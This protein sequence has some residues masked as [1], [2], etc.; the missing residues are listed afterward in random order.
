MTGAP[1][2]LG[3]LGLL[4]M[5]QAPE[6]AAVDDVTWSAPDGCPD[7]EALLAAVAARRSGPLVAGQARIVGRTTLAAPRRYRL[8]LELEVRGRR[9]D[10]VLVAHTCS[11]LVDAAALVIAL[12]VDGEAGATATAPEPAPEPTSE[13]AS[14]TPTSEP[15]SETPTS[16]PASETVPAPPPQPQIETPTPR[17]VAVT[18]R[19]RPGG[20]LR[21]H[22]LGELGAL[23]GA[24]GGV[25][26]A[27]GLLW[28]WF[29][30]ELT[31]TWLAPRT[32]ERH[33]VRL[34]T[35]LFAAAALGCAR[36][37]VGRVELPVCLGLEVGGL[38]GIAD[39]GRALGRWFAGVASVGAAVRLHP[40]IALWAS[41]YGLLA[42]QRGTFVVRDP[43]PE[44]SVFDPGLGSG[45]LALGVELRFGDRR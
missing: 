32:I 34:R 12:A 24:S 11:A 37:A 16:E 14:E 21:V 8:E 28:R 35:S 39:T 10:R 25:G 45:R 40:R 41:L 17:P 13:P 2:L 1:G 33:D 38:P 44:R 7:R 20:L 26:L 19:W 4:V 31:A 29:R 6:P 30:L 36:P 27:G 42:F 5:T 22:G 23:P 15:A 9:D 3:A 18:S 43:G